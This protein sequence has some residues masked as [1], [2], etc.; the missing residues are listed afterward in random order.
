MRFHAISFAMSLLPAVIFSVWQNPRKVLDVWSNILYVV[1]TVYSMLFPFRP[2][3]PV[4]WLVGVVACDGLMVHYS[5]YAVNRQAAQ[6]F[7][8]LF[9]RFVHSCVYAQDALYNGSRAR[10]AAGGRMPGA[11]GDA[12][13]GRRRSDSRPRSRRS[14]RRNPPC[15]PLDVPP[16]MVSPHTPFPIIPPYNP[17][18]KRKI[19]IL[20]YCGGNL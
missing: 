5:V 19:Y 16:L 6:G 10:G 2:Y 4:V 3:R 7:A 18:I 20:F 8:L 14:R 9:V 12:M 11:D 1:W 17:P 13:P 15:S